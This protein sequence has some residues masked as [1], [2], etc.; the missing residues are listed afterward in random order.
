M[1][2][3]VNIMIIEMFD[4]DKGNF[5]RILGHMLYIFCYTSF[6]IKLKKKKP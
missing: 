6:I 4:Y 3:V 2:H 1:V 5:F